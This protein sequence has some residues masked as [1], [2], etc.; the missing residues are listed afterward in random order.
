M[1]H[2]MS[3]LSKPAAFAALG[4]IM[5][6]AFVPRDFEAALAHWTGVMGV[7]PFFVRENVAFDSV[8]L[9]GRPI[10]FRMSMAL[11]Y[12]GAIQIELV[13]L[14]DDGPSIFREW[15]NAGREGM[16]HVAISVADMG[17]ARR[18]ALA[19]GAVVRQ[20][21][22]LPDGAG[23]AVYLQ[24]GGEAGD[25]VELIRLAS[26]RLAGFDT[27]RNAAAHWD[28]RDPIRRR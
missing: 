3:Q 19:A 6:I 10:E 17:E 14:D 12:W 2:I 15:R 24:V 18:A 16:H 1:L 21:A 5:Q 9:D 22:V 13:R 8:M 7:G 20:E 4:D 23:E 26:D 28:G 11:A 27:L 25:I